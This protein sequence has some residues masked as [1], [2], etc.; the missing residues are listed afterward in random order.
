MD[1]I[2]E[3]YKDPNLLREK[4][5]N[6]KPFPHII[7]DGFISTDLLEAVEAEFPDLSSIKNKIEFANQKEVKFASKGN[8]DFSPSA[9]KLVNYFNSEIFLNYIKGLTGIKETLIS[10][11]YFSGGGYHEIKN[12]GYLKVHADFN[13]HPLLDLDRRVNLLIYLNKKWDSK[14]KGNLELYDQNDFSSPVIS[15]EPIFNRCLIFSTT[16]FNFHG[17]P[18]KLLCPEKVSRKSIALFYFSTGR[19][20]EEISNTNDPIFVATKGEKFRFDIH[21]FAKDFLPPFLLRKLKKLF[22][23]NNVNKYSK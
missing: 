8:L 16:S 23:I 19:P 14:W 5:L 9:H 20:K 1:I 4:Y 18:D 17:H 12:G 7:L 6:N 10:D 11:P 15:I 13:K 2:S 22:Q 3:K 21:S